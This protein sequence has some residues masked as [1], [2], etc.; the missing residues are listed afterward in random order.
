MKLC[1][2]GGGAVRE[3]CQLGVGG[4]L[5]VTNGRV[6]GPAMDEGA[7][8]TVAVDIPTRERLEAQ[9]DAT[10]DALA[11]VA[12]AMADPDQPGDHEAYAR[13]IDELETVC[14]QLVHLS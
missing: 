5:T 3:P 7:T 1:Y 6:S 11:A 13:L 4:A 14:G 9:R 8:M 2:G 12:E 10:L